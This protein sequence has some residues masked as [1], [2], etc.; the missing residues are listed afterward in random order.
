MLCSPAGVFSPV[1]ERRIPPL[2]VF[3]TLGTALVGGLANVGEDRLGEL[4]RL[5]DVGVDPLVS[6]AHDNYQM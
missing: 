1:D 3:L 2:Q 5:G 4:R 6:L